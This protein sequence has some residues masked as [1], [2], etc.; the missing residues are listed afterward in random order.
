MR[1]FAALAVLS[2]SALLCFTT[3]ASGQGQIEESRYLPLGGLKLADLTANP[4]LEQYFKLW[5]KSIESGDALGAFN[6][7][8]HILEVMR[9]LGTRN[10]FALA[11]M[12]LAVGN[13]VLAKDMTEAAVT[14]GQHAIMF[15]P[16]HPK[17]HF[18]LAS[19]LFAHNRTDLN[20]VAVELVS[21]VKA[22]LSD[23]IQRDKFISL[24]IRYMILA[25]LL[26]FMLTFLA[27][28][29]LHYQALLSDI[30]DMIPSRPEG[31]W[32]AVFGALVLLVPLAVGGWFLFL[33]AIPLFLWPYLRS[34]G[35][36]VVLLFAIFILSGPF[37]FQYMARG[38]TLANADTYRALYLLSKNTWDQETK[39]VLE[40]EKRKKPD[41]EL[42][43]FALGLLNKLRKDKDASIEAYDSVLKTNPRS[44]RALVN[45][46]NTFFIAKDYD[47]AVNMYK[48]ALKVD[49]QSVVAHFNLSNAYAFMAKTKDS[50]SEYNMALSIDLDRTRKLVEMGGEGQESKVVDFPITARDL[51]EFERAVA[52]NTKAVSKVLWSV[53]FGA[54]SANVYQFVAAG[55]LILLA[56]SHFY[57]SRNMSHKVCSSCG[58]PFRPPLRVVSDFPRCNQCV[59]AQL[60]KGGVSSVKK[61]KKR[62]EIRQFID[63]Q[64]R[65]ARW[66][67][68]L[69]PG[70]GRA[71]YHEQPAGFF[72]IL[73]T[74][75]IIVYGVATIVTE[76]VVYKAPITAQI[77]KAHAV[78]LGTA[79]LYWI[80]MN[81]ALKRDFY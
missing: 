38:I 28:T 78:Y 47:K 57:W 10:L 14:A 8:N 56:F 43:A 48:E 3:P 16:D 12:C 63:R 65:T 79:A 68:Y 4:A 6:E 46:G 26:S 69:I 22:L 58:T 30:A 44:L 5:T 34:N 77:A 33:L 81:T 74:S 13:G 31:L 36:V 18:F 15:A 35:K 45:K 23:M 59:A 60:S 80:T 51:Q 21:G 64:G 37:L 72:F 76:I 66:L 29:A 39:Q 62:K 71:Y 19:A 2:L 41:D 9:E 52:Q 70:L 61:D 1:P 54:I 50:E 27:F 67:D 32:R 53:Y 73:I 7:A 25:L 24:A 40:N 20:S 17:A 11:D 75:L 49:P 42:I 55:F